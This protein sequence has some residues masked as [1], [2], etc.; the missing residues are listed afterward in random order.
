MNA[1]CI[2]HS[3]RVHVEE[4]RRVILCAHGFQ[5]HMVAAVW[6]EHGA[7]KGI[8][9][10][11]SWMLVQHPEKGLL[12]LPL[13]GNGRTWKS[14][15]ENMDVMIEVCTALGWIEVH[16]WGLIEAALEHH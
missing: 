12:G 14:Q 16:D 11:E 4:N 1:P 6:P 5:N 13:S 3:L 15:W 7:L 8:V 9:T 10:R 2:L